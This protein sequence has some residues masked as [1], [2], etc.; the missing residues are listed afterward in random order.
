MGP[1]VEYINKSDNIT[2]MMDVPTKPNE[3]NYEINKINVQKI[4][5]LDL[6]KIEKEIVESWVISYPEISDNK[7]IKIFLL[8]LKNIG[9]ESFLFIKKKNKKAKIISIGPYVDRSMAIS[10]KNKVN[11]LINHD[12]KILRIS[13]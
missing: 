1:L 5:V 11:K 3:Y 7:D 13:N 10:M 6:P 9:I 2:Y 12:G 8:K 4:D